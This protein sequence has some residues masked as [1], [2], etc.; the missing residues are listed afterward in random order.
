MIWRNEHMAGLVPSFLSAQSPLSAAEQIDLHYQHGGG[1]RSLPGFTL[2]PAKGDW[3]SL[4]HLT[5]P[6]AVLLYPKDPP[7]RELA[8]TILRDEAIILFSASFIAIAQRDGNY[9]V[10]RID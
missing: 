10:A 7:F 8:R 5:G 1:W 9:D 2:V 6:E 3:D 4:F